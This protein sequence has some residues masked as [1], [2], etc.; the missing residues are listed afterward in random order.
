[1]D[2]RTLR[3]VVVLGRAG[4]EAKFVAAALEERGWRVTVR[5]QVAPGIAVGSASPALDTARVGAAIA[6]DST[7]ASEA[8]AIARYVRA[9]GGLVLGA[10]AARLPAFAALTAG[11]AGATVRTAASYAAAVAPVT[12]QTLAIAPLNA[13]RPDAVV[14]ERRDADVVLAAR[15]VDAGRV[16]QLGYDETWRWRLAGGDESPEAHRRW[17]SEL[18]GSVAYAPS[19]DGAAPALANEP[20]PRAALVAALG[21]ASAAPTGASASPPFDPSRSLLVYIGVALLL[22]AEWASRRLRGAK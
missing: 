13:I 10:E 12:Q 21:E 18:V 11:R 6:L 8:A 20:A 3:T 2:A 4:W 19:A 7:A 14:L 5:M 1:M 9:G 15:R 17:W 16:V 22:C